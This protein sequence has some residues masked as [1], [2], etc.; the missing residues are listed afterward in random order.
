[1]LY[2]STSP[3]L[4]WWCETR[5]ADSR[6][7]KLKRSDLVRQF[8]SGPY[9]ELV[10]QREGKLRNVQGPNSALAKFR[11]TMCAKCNNERSQPFDLAYDKFTAYLHERERHVLASRSVD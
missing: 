9:P 6:E 4:C 10:S 1:M 7:H 11:Q 8:G 2:A 5:A 3:G